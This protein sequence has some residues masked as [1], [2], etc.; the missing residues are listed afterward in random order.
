V[1]GEAVSTDKRKH[2]FRAEMIIDGKNAGIIELP[3]DSR[4]RNPTPFWAYGLAAGPHEVIFRILN[5]AEGARLR[6]Q[7]AVVYAEAK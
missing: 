7:D 2:V 6:L 5:P 4:L 1:N 3:T